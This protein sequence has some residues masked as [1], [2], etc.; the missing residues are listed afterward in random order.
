M[1]KP[2]I[3]VSAVTVFVEIPRLLMKMMGKMRVVWSLMLHYG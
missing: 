2:S 1:T 3:F